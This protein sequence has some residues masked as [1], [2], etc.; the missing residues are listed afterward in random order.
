[1]HRAIRRILPVVALGL[2]T[3]LGGCIIAPE[4]GGWGHGWWGHDRGGW[5]R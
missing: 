3:L 5:H 1:M 2:A 4:R